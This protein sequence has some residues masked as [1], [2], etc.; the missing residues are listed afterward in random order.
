MP[1]RVQDLLVEVQRLHLHR[2]P[3]PP[4]PVLRS[5][6]VPREGSTNLLC[7]ERRFVRLQ[8][9][10]TQR[11]HIKYSEV[12]VVRARKHVP[13]RSSYQIQLDGLQ[14]R[15]L[16]NLCPTRYTRTCRRC[17]RSRT[18]R[19]VFPSGDRGWGSSSPASSPY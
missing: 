14:D 3:Q 12:V 17:N 8:N 13:E 6:F 5:Q 10:I 19:T 18:D 2:V 4:R 1:T 11:V 16:T 15:L 7:L 9:N